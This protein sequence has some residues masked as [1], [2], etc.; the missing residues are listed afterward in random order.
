MPAQHVDLSTNVGPL[1]KDYKDNELR[2][3]N[4]YKGKRV[5]LSGIAGEIKRDITNTPFLTVGTGSQFEIPVAQCFFGEEYVS[6]LSNIHPGQP[7]LVNCE[8]QGLMM[9]VLLKDCSFPSVVT[10]NVCVALKNAGVATECEGAPGDKDEVN[11]LTSAPPVNMSAPCPDGSECQKK[12]KAWL[13]KAFGTVF[14][15]K[16]AAGY[17]AYVPKLAAF[18][19]PN[20]PHDGPRYKVLGS[21]AARII[22]ALPHSASAA[23]EAKTKAVLDKLPAATASN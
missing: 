10:N 11:F 4:K 5:R 2:A 13:S 7:V 14:M 6:N 9:N 18:V 1:L 22:V 3:D 21:P 15:M 8:V 19:D 20:A 23:Q 12:L 16:D 17:S